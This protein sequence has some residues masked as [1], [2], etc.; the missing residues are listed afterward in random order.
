MQKTHKISSKHFKYIK[1]NKAITLIALVI[2]IIVM[3]ILVGVTVTLAMKGNLFGTARQATKDTQV[4]T[5][6]ET[7]QVAIVDAFNVKTRILDKEKLGDNLRD[8]LIDGEGPFICISS[9]KNEFTVGIDGTIMEEIDISKLPENNLVRMYAEKRLKQGDY[10]SYTPDTVTE[11]YDPDKG[12]GAGSLTGASRTQSISQEE[13]NWRVLGYD[14]VSKKILLISG[15]PTNTALSFSRYIGYNNYENIIN[16]VC[17]KLYSKKGIGTA[18]SINMNDIDTYLGGDNFNKAEFNGGSS[19][20]GGYGYSKDFTNIYN[21]E[22]WD[23]KW[24]GT[25]TSTNYYY[26]I[27]DVISD[28]TKKEILQGKNENALYSYSISSK[29]TMV[30]DTTVSWDLGL[31][32]GRLCFCWILW[33][34]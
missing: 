24:S 32:Y 3:I 15:A 14:E 21:P 23:G 34:L 6:K 7:L 25:L 27:N 31:F 8:W 29:Y 9:N 2:T 33:N 28:L 20:P 1:S 11:S 17:N 18:R 30:N 4:Q 10:V 13:L 16:E 19:N 12:Q 22:Q 5:D 26:A